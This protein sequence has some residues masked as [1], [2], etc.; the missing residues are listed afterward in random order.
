VVREDPVGQ[1]VW[2]SLDDA[3]GSC[4]S[5]AAL[6]ELLG[7][8]GV[9]FVMVLLRLRPLPPVRSVKF[10]GMTLPIASA[11]GLVLGLAAFS[12]STGF[13]RALLLSLLRSLMPLADRS[14]L[15]VARKKVLATSEW[16]DDGVAE[17]VASTGERANE[18]PVLAESVAE[19]VSWPGVSVQP[20]GVG[21]TGPKQVPVCGACR[22]FGRTAGGR[23]RFENISDAPPAL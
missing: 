13:S 20:A 22:V 14:R 7:D 10:A 6:R 3:L 12:S 9:S 8:L 5:R 18:L 17:L 19:S 1:F 2:E 15:A 16:D 4:S 21:G 23:K 11:H